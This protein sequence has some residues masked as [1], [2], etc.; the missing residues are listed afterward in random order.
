MHAAGIE[1]QTYFETFGQAATYVVEVKTNPDG[2]FVKD[3]VD[4]QL[5][6]KFTNWYGWDAFDGL[7]QIH[8]AGP[9]TYFDNEAFSQPYTRT[10]WC[11]AKVRGGTR[12]CSA[13]RWMD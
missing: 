13:I 10:H 12:K 11:P 8:W 7:G 3:S 6:R 4:S 5:T 1:T 2:T 9:H